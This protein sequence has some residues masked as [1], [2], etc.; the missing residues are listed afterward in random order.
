MKKTVTCLVFAL[1]L[2]GCNTTS[3]QSP[4]IDTAPFDPKAAAYIKT[5][6]TGR[7]EGH[8]FLRKP[9]GGVMMAAG[10][11]VRL[12]PATPYAR[13]RFAKLYNGGKFVAAHQIPQVPADPTYTDYTR[14]VK[15]E[16]SGRFAFDNVAPGQ[17]FIATQIIIKPEAGGPAKGGAF[18]E[19]VSLTGKEAEPVK[20][21]V[22]G[23]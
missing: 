17:Y 22:N 14:L 11:F 19:N 10:E 3:Q 5:Q 15:A 6:G 23:N 18:F 8:A 20:V 2:A 13:N 21:I 16:S 9:E 4:Q 7:I 12:V 1:A